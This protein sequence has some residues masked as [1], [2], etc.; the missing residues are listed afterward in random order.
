MV[1]LTMLTTIL[2]TPRARKAIFVLLYVYAWMAGI[3][4]WLHRI[5]SP[6]LGIL[7]GVKYQG[8]G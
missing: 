6:T 1:Y 5:R 3:G 4:K 2:V 7:Q 8:Q